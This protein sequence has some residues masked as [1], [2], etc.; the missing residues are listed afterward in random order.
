MYTLE[1]DVGTGQW[2]IYGTKAEL[3]AFL[4]NEEIF[5][6]VVKQ[7]PEEDRVLMVYEAF[8]PAFGKLIRTMLQRCDKD[9]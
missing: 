2:I 4:T 8:I 6:S 5:Y 3:H 1:K 9:K 7:I